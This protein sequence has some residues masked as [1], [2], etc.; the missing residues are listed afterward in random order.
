MFRR[1]YDLKL[2]RSYTPFFKL[3]WSL[4]HPLDEHSPIKDYDNIKESL[5]AVAVTVTGHDGTFSTTIY[6]RHIYT[7]EEIVEDRYFKDIMKLNSKGE[8]SIDYNQFDDFED[9]S[10]S[11][12]LSRSGNPS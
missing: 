3:S 9:E 7:P 2:V 4:F 12:S 6:G 10:A 5:Q 8:I 1:I 11:D